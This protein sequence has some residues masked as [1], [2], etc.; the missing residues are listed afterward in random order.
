MSDRRGMILLDALLGLLMISVIAL[1]IY[2]ASS[3]RDSVEF[4]P[5]SSQMEE[6]WRDE[7]YT[8]IYDPAPHVTSETV[9]EELTSEENV[10]D[11]PLLN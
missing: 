4:D 6:L 9:L 2:G 8:E 3:L 5:A 1:L 10:Q 11:L 7:E